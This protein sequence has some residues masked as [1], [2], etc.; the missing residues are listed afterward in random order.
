MSLIRFYIALLLFLNTA[1]HSI[2]L[3]CE[4]DLHGEWLIEIGDNLAY[5][6]PNYNDRGWETIPVPCPWENEGF[7]GYDG[8]AWYRT[9]FV[10]PAYLRNRILLLR[11]GQIDDVDRC[12]FNGHLIGGH[13]DFPPNYQTA[14]DVVRTYQI[15]SGFI[16]YDRKN[17]LSVRVF[18]RQGSG[19]IVHGDVGVYSCNDAL[20]LEYDLSG[21]WRFKL[22]DDPRWADKDFADGS[23]RSIA[24][25]CYWHLQG[26]SQAPGYGWYRRTFK[27]NNV[28]D[29]QKLIL[30]L[31]KINEMDQVYFN[32][33][34]IGE[35]GVFQSDYEP[36]QNGYKDQ[37]RTY[38]IPNYLILSNAVNTIAVRVYA[39][40][41]YGGIYAG[42]VGICTRQEFLRHAKKK[43]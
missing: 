13:G 29:E 20:R 6:S 40:S 23:W 9:S 2:D 39:P 38:Y 31:G 25:P 15:P 36:L 17:F 24:V 1:L 8:Y 21:L 32:G 22:G 10:I 26:F 4:I 27:I 3:T 14:Y 16:Q 19:G 35:T 41:G 11:L 33:V 34:Q 18:D 42:H 12:Y 7:P 28:R 37:E 5:A 43:K 30:V